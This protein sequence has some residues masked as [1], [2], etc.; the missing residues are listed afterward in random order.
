MYKVSSTLPIF[1]LII[2]LFTN[3][4]IL[5]YISKW[6]S[7]IY[8]YWYSRGKTWK[9]V[10][11]MHRKNVLPW[12]Q[13]DPKSEMTTRN[14]KS[15]PSATTFMPLLPKPEKKNKKKKEKPRKHRWW[16]QE[17]LCCADITKMK[18]NSFRERVVI[19]VFLLE[20]YLH[21]A[22]EVTDELSS[23][24]ASY[25]LTI[26]DTG[27]SLYHFLFCSS[28][29]S[30]QQLCYLFPYDFSLILQLFF[31]FFMIGN[32]PNYSNLV[33]YLATFCFFL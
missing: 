5:L 28:S 10:P 14:Y 1:F 4:D 12:K 18:L 3:K 17:G 2:Q 23:G 13:R 33:S 25:L 30:T 7:H 29:L 16:W 11:I 9:R 24:D 27:L 21:S 20:F 22:L 32:T 8:C 26:V 6:R 31:D 19:L 15:Q